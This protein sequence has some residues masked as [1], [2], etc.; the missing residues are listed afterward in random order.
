MVSDVKIQKWED[1]PNRHLYIDRK[2]MLIDAPWGRK[3]NIMD[4]SVKNYGKIRFLVSFKPFFA[5]VI[6][7][8]VCC[9]T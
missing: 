7:V 5:N 4:K 1:Y 2:L 9:V 8:P 3:E 6:H